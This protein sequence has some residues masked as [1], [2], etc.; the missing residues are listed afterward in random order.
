MSE[1]EQNFPVDYYF[2]CVLMIFDSENAYSQYENDRGY[3]VQLKYHLTQR[4]LM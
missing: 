2:L 3:V 4:T 1:S